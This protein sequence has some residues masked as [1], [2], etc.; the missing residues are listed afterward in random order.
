[1]SCVS[2]NGYRIGRRTPVILLLLVVVAQL[3]FALGGSPALRLQD[4]LGFR[5]LGL[6]GDRRTG[7]EALGRIEVLQVSSGGRSDCLKVRNGIVAER[8]LAKDSLVCSRCVSQEGGAPLKG[9]RFGLGK[10]KVSCQRGN[11]PCGSTGN[12]GTAPGI[13]GI[14]SRRG[15]LNILPLLTR[16]STARSTSAVSNRLAFD[17]HD[18]DISSAI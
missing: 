3:A 15:G 12:R 13:M 10:G 6:L 2:L 9:G 18:T 1:M 11:I 14:E 4:G 7:L 16:L 5:R 17:E 8:H